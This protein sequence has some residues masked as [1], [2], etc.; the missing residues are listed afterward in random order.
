MVLEGPLDHLVEKVSRNQFVDI[1]AGETLC[2]RLGI[3]EL[4]I[5]GG[6]WGCFTYNDICDYTVVG[7]KN[8]G[9][10]IRNKFLH[11]FTASIEIARRISQVGSV[12]DA[13]RTPPLNNSRGQSLFRVIRNIRSKSVDHS[14]KM[15][16]RTASD[17][18][19]LHSRTKRPQDGGEACVEKVSAKR[20]ERV[21][22][23]EGFLAL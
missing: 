3:Y 20:S 22:V 7:P 2:E 19:D 23:L 17:L 13:L 1:C 21:I 4:V 6:E 5:Y 12:L 15:S 9:V 8:A 10:Q 16:V 14:A 11:V 18:G